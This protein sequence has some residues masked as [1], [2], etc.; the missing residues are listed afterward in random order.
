MAERRDLEDLRKP[1]KDWSLQDLSI[2][3]WLY[4]HGRGHNWAC[5]RAVADVAPT[6]RSFAGQGNME[7]ASLAPSACNRP[8]A[9]TIRVAKLDGHGS[10]GGDRI[11]LYCRLYTIYNTQYLVLSGNG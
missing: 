6:I 2:L 1:Y 8:A 9:K 10:Q 4:G 11:M 3:Q 7:E 5:M